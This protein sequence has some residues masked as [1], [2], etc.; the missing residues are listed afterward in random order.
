MDEVSPGI[1]P[2]GIIGGPPCQGFSRGNARANPDDPRNLLPFKYA[3]ILAELNERSQ[4]HFFVFENVMG[5][6][7]RVHIER[8]RAIERRFED[9][10]FNI[11]PQ[12]LNAHSFGVAQNR[13]RLFIVGLNSTL[14]PNIKFE[15][16]K[17]R[18]PRHCVRDAIEGLPAPAFFRRGITGEEIPHHP[19][20]W[21]MTPKSPKLGDGASTDGRSFRKLLWDQESPTV[22]YGNREIHIHPDGGRRLSVHEAML[23]QGFP[24]SYK[25][26]GNFGQQVTQVCNAVP[27]PVARALARRIRKTLWPQTNGAQRQSGSSLEMEASDGCQSRDCQSG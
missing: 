19:N 20:H 16:P 13:R 14:H 3:D 26:W 22:A 23:L 6:M 2:V 4:I 1:S 15:F 11:F 7:N 5:L 24:R 17:G 10:G 9:A 27:P 12:E 25:L 18:G 21:T 8:F